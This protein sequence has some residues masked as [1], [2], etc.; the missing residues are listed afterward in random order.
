MLNYCWSFI[1]E[2]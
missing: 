2:K 1:D